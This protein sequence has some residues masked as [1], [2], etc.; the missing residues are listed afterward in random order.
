MNVE[1]LEKEFLTKP[2]QIINIMN[3][4]TKAK[5][6]FDKYYPDYGAD[7]ALKTTTATQIMMAEN[8]T[9]KRERFWRH[10]EMQVALAYQSGREEMK[11]EE[12]QFI[13]NVLDGIDIADEQMGNKTGGTKAIRQALQS[14][15]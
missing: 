14:R 7:I 12:R 6:L 13:L 9:I 2:H 1:K 11:K 8:E 4:I 3:H 10:I 15:V 5:E